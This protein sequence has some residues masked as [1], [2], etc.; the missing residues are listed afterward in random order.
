MKSVSVLLIFII[1]ECRCISVDY[2]LGKEPEPQEQ[3]PNATSTKPEVPDER[4]TSHR[5]NLNAS[6]KENVIQIKVMDYGQYEGL[7]EI[8]ED[9]AHK[10]FESK[11]PHD[12][13]NEYTDTKKE[14]A[15]V[16]YDPNLMLR[17]NPY[18]TSKKKL[19]FDVSQDYVYNYEDPQNAPQV[20]RDK[21]E[22]IESQTEIDFNK[23]VILKN[24]KSEN[25]NNEKVSIDFY[26]LV[27]AVSVNKDIEDTFSNYS[28]LDNNVWYVPET[29]QCWELPMLYGELGQAKKS[30]EVFLMYSGE[31]KNVVE[32]KEEPSQ[33]SR[34]LYIPVAQTVNKWCAAGPCYGDHTLCL[35]SDK[36]NS[37]L[38]R[39]GYVVSTPTMI[40]Q[41]GLVNT[42]NS[43][44][45]RIANG[46]TEFYAHL[47]TAA[48][49]N[50]LI[51]DLDLESMAAAWLHQ[52]LP[53]PASCSALEGNYVTQLECTK[54]ARNCCI[55]SFKTEKA[56]K[57]YLLLI[58]CIPTK[59][60]RNLSVSNNKHLVIVSSIP[61]YE[62]YVDPIIGCIHVWF[63]AAGKKLTTTDIECGHITP[64]T[65]YTVQLLWAD[66]HKIG[67]AYG[68]KVGG[69][70]RVVCKF[71]PGA[72]FYI[73]TKYY[74]GFITH[75][76]VLENFSSSLMTSDFLK[77]LGIF[78]TPVKNSE[79]MNTQHASHHVNY[80][81]RFSDIDV[82]AKNYK[83]NWIR[84]KLNMTA[85]NTLGLVARL[86]ARYTFGEDGGSQCDMNEA[87]YE[88]GEPGSKCVERGRRF[89]A[90]CYD[91]RDPTPGY[92]LVAVL[93]PVA[94]FSLILYDLFSGVVR[95]TN[96]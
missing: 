65:Y 71:S 5:K 17:H 48:D 30:G 60:R 29:T 81:L 94:L 40:E 27:P 15:E 55:D 72:P 84:E 43:M 47:P 24:V 87:I 96:Y 20:L 49:M 10:A 23:I 12:M 89:H 95:Q 63:A 66:T 83:R 45:N 77:G 67:C 37:P 19:L 64:E 53:G 50:Q 35:F 70:I 7:S 58:H 8:E 1:V 56:S 36:I 62:C 76:P 69:D 52:C 26:N 79:Y 51:Y 44:R 85:N 32:T 91:F 9:M 18:D 42:V 75:K 74:C 61:K 41:I 59:Y 21:N 73:D 34:P 33:P 2:Y 78:L 28:V 80:S 90:L 39:E 13:S 31:L 25:E 68:T 16:G 86:V 22:S 82:L 3:K 92:R 88:S 4:E 54:Y 6:S 11:L 46:E 93:A 38:C 57:W 14:R